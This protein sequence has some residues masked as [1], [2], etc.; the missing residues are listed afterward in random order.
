MLRS[1]I[2]TSKVAEVGKGSCPFLLT[3]FTSGP[4]QNQEQKLHCCTDGPAYGQ[5]IPISLG[6][7]KQKYLGDKYFQTSVYFSF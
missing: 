1:N 4:E 6:I 7:L 2:F 3:M 5:L